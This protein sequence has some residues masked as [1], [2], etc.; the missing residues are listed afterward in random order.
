MKKI[1]ILLIL[2]HIWVQYSAC[3]HSRAGVVSEPAP[4]PS[5]VLEPQPARTICNTCSA[6]ITGD[7]D[8][9]GTAHLLNDEDFSYRVE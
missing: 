7:V 8:S 6:V 1:A 5:V 3:T 4:T 2:C 9:H